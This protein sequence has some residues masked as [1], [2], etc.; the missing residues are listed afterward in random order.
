MILLDSKNFRRNKNWSEEE[1]IAFINVWRDHY[2]KLM[3]TTCRN[4]PVYNGMALQLNQM[5]LGRILDGADIKSKIGHLVS[6]YRKKKRIHGRTGSSPPTWKYFD[7][8][9]EIIGK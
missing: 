4:T 7:L 1:T 8:I 2:E 6:E 9:D 3:S 5:L